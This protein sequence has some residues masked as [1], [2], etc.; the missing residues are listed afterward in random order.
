M[1]AF[2]DGVLIDWRFRCLRFRVRFLAPMFRFHEVLEG[3]VLVGG[4]ILVERNLRGCVLVERSLRGCVLVERSLRGC[5]LV[6]RSLRGCVLL[7]NSLRGCVLLEKSLGGVLSLGDT[8]SAEM[9]SFSRVSMFFSV[10]PV[11]WFI[12]R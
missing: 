11:L 10:L 7:E 4:C 8:T 1:I 12:K 5:V 2:V 3:A 6:E 9:H